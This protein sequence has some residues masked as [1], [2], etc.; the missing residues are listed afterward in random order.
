LAQDVT[1]KEKRRD[2]A[3]VRGKVQ[4]KPVIEKQQIKEDT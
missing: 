4:R 2:M 3:R 1:E